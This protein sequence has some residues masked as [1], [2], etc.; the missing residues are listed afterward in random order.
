MVGTSGRILRSEDIILE[1]QYHLNA[2][3]TKIDRAEPQQRNAASTSAEVCILENHP[4]YAVL[5]VTCACGT[6]MRLRCEYASA[7]T[8]NNSQ[9][10][11][12]TAVESDYMK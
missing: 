9:I 8:L 10:Q 6:K 12:N 3:R 7:K 2:G 4:E 11:N 1:G 5:E